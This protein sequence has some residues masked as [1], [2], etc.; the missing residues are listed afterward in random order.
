MIHVLRI[1]GIRTEGSHGASAGERDRPQPFVIDLE[2]QVEATGDSVDL[3]AD[4]R[5]LVATVRRV[6][7]TESHAL[8]ETIARRV[9]EEVAAT[10]GVVSC[11]AV[12]HKPEAAGRLG[13]R[14]VS[15][16]AR[17]GSATPQGMG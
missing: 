15:A 9:A 10:S 14:D 3:T 6:V 13:V 11:R 12:V 4:Y 7:G 8:I 2:L 16:D 5:D 1:E 17:A